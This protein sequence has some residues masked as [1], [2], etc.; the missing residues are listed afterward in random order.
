MRGRGGSEAYVSIKGMNTAAE[1]DMSA[2][3]WGTTPLAR[4][5]AAQKA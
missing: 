4:M 5:S 1:K 3:L 2:L